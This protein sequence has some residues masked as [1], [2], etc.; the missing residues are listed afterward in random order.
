MSQSIGRRPAQRRRAARRRRVHD[1]RDLS[2]RLNDAGFVIGKHHRNQRPRG[3]LQRDVERHEIDHAVAGDRERL[4]ALVGKTA[5]GCEPK[6]AR[7][8][9]R[10][11][12]SRGS[13]RPAT[14]NAGV[15]ASM[16]ASVAPL[17][18]VTFFGIGADQMGDLLARLLHQATDGAALGVHGG[19][20]SGQ[21][22]GAAHGGPR[23]LAQRGGGIPVEIRALGHDFSPVS[24]YRFALEPAKSLLFA[25]GIVLEA[26][27]RP[28]L[29]ACVEAG[30]SEIRII[31][32]ILN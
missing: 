19:S 18:N 12:R 2:D 22:Q 31:R 4:D 8:R 6:D 1:L 28:V 3:L 17:V 20:I 25:L 32:I 29:I 13:L 9:I 24:N 30:N 27:N 11:D 5:A 26:R 10:T 14:S 23:L 7:L 16:L 15:R 21:S